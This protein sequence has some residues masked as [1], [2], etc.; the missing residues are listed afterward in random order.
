[1]TDLRCSGF[2]TVM[3]N[4]GTLSLRQ[5]VEAVTAEAIW[6]QEERLRALEARVDSLEEAIHRALETV[7]PRVDA[8]VSQLEKQ[9]SCPTRGCSS[10]SDS[11]LSEQLAQVSISSVRTEDNTGS[12]PIQSTASIANSNNQNNHPPAYDSRFSPFPTFASACSP[13][14]FSTSPACVGTSSSPA[15]QVPLS[16]P[17]SPSGS[18]FTFAPCSSA[19]VAIPMPFVPNS[20]FPPFSQVPANTISSTTVASSTRFSFPL[21]ACSPTFSQPSV[22]SSFNPILCSARPPLSSRIVSS[23][24]PVHLASLVTTTSASL[25]CNTSTSWT[26]FHPSLSQDHFS[27]GVTFSTS[28]PSDIHSPLPCVSTGISSTF[29]TVS[30]PSSC[31]SSNQLSPIGSGGLGQLHSAPD[32]P[33]AGSF[34][35]VIQMMPSSN[36]HVP[37]S[38][39]SS[40]SPTQQV[41][42]S[43]ASTR[44]PIASPRSAMSSFAST[45]SSFLP[46]VLPIHA[47]SS[48]SDRSARSYPTVSV[49]RFPSTPTSSVP[50]VFSVPNVFGLSCVPSAWR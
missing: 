9:G 21:T 27:G 12:V 8:L 45:P 50:S 43:R 10:N 24:Q 3:D 11:V 47:N 29:T 34:Q 16:T 26:C 48:P 46:S 13:V 33:S 31:I 5:L 19:N 14:S 18:S 2:G 25:P 35:N 28:S 41:I 36:V 15:V 30:L 37:S 6:R 42:C 1:M 32:V 39:P 4:E 22:N 20:C 23:D 17:E 44:T 38:S 40:S 7:F 49:S